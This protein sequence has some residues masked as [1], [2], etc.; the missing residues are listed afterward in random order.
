MY[1]PAYTYSPAQHLN[2]IFYIG[3]VKN[4]N[5]IAQMAQKNCGYGDTAQPEMTESTC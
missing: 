4:L 2:W 3:G 1:P 5:A